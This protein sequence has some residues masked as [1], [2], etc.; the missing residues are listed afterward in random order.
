M[1]IV[2]IAGKFDPPHEGHIAH[3]KA[4]AKLGN[5]LYVITHSDDIVAKSS[6]KGVCLLKY[7][8]RRDLLQGLLLLYGINGK[9]VQSIDTDGTVA[10]TLEAI[11]PHIFAKGG[12]RMPHNMPNDELHVCRKIKCEVVYDVGGRKLAA[13]SELY[14]RMATE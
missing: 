10:M 1:K 2:V 3:I 5:F 12:D 8:V 11:M 4:A 13:S 14:K 9:V 6:A 7:E